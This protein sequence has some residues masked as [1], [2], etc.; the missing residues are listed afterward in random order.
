[1]LLSEGG[2]KENIL[3]ILLIEAPFRIGTVVIVCIVLFPYF[4]EMIWVRR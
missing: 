4:R 3:L 2:N 1:M